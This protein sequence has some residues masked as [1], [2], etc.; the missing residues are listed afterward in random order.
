[1]FSVSLCVRMQRRE[2]GKGRGERVSTAIQWQ[3]ER[4]Y[5]R[6]VAVPV[7]LHVELQL[8]TELEVGS[9]VDAHVNVRV[10]EGAVGM[11]PY[12]LLPQS[13]VPIQEVWLAA[14]HRDGGVLD[15][16][17]VDE[18]VVV[19]AA[20][21]GVGRVAERREEGRGVQ[22]V[23]PRL[24]PQVLH[25]LLLVEVKRAHDI[26][27][28]CL[29]GLSLVDVGLEEE[30]F[31]PVDVVGRVPGPDGQP[32]QSIPLHKLPNPLDVLDARIDDGGP[33]VVDRGVVL[34][35]DTAAWVGQ[36]RQLQDF[37]CVELPH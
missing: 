28:K 5:S 17:Q 10:V 16:S 31:C 35:V 9:G 29:Q 26:I 13:G 23:A 22:H 37:I 2:R 32:G 1:M 24:Q 14:V 18:P 7:G 33:A 11:H 3:R 6:K 34:Q 27:H 36:S 15:H 20:P 8:P 12:H 19:P 4:G 30:S 25:L 21:A